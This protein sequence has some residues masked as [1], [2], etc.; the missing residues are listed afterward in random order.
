MKKIDFNSIPIMDFGNGYTISGMVFTGTNGNSIITPLPEEKIDDTS[1]GLATLSKE[2]WDRLLKQTD[3]NEVQGMRKGQKT[4]LRKSQRNIDSKISWNVF[5]RDDFK[6]RYCAIDFVPM[7]VDH[8]I[9]WELGGATHEDNLLCS[10]KKCNRT[11]GNTLYEDWLQTDYY[12]EKSKFL[13]Q[14]I[15][16]KN[17]L[18]IDKLHELPR[19]E[20]IRN[21]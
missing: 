19:V 1:F 8:I 18:I 4:I 20:V 7:T 14:D 3:Y 10:C 9:T 11:R 5:R 2:D 6:C 15:K 13:T 12:K 17:A 16:L 21:R